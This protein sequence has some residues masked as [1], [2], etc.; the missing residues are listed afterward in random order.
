LTHP[1][2]LDTIA[3]PDCDLQ[4]SI[5]PLPPGGSARCPRCRVVVARN[6]ANPIELPLSLTVASAIVYLIANFTPLMGL[7]AVGRESTTTIFGGAV[8]MWNQGSE[9]TAAAVAFCAVVA[10]GGFIAFMLI[11]LTAALRPPAPRWVG[12]MF[13]VAAWMQP[14]SMTEV[15]L[16]GILVALIKIAQLATVVPGPGM[17]AIGV[18]VGL[19]AGVGSTFD[20]HVIWTRVVWADGTL[21]PPIPALPRPPRR[22]QAGAAR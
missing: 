12:R 14:W 16:L 2:A 10:P 11:V 13:R 21:P 9:V 18:L 19:L 5:P 3:C 20:A 15:M 7:S 17:Y 4:Q 6:P 8:E 1:P 22:G